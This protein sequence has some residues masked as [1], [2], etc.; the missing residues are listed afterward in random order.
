MRSRLSEPALVEGEYVEAARGPVGEDVR[1]A[2]DVFYEAVEEDEDTFWGGSAC[3]SG[4]W[5]SSSRRWG[6]GLGLGLSGVSAYV[7]FC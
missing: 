4:S 6:S 2:A 5:W 7:E 3:S 1:V